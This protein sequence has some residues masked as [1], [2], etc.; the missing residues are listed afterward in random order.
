MQFTFFDSLSLSLSVSL[1]VFY[2]R[3][4]EKV[5]I[6]NFETQIISPKICWERSLKVHNGAMGGILNGNR[7][8]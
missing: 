4:L 1:L 8:K 7:K 2:Y 3:P 5:C 6:W